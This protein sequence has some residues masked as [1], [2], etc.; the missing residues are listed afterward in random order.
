[1]KNPGFE[2]NLH[3]VAQEPCCLLLA[4]NFGSRNSIVYLPVLGCTGQS[5]L[6]LIHHAALKSASI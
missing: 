4:A 1:M 6:V 3:N 5:L 2:V